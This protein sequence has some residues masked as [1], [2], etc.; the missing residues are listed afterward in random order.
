MIYGGPFKGS[1]LGG[2]LALGVT[3]TSLTEN[4]GSQAAEK[5]ALREAGRLALAGTFS[6]HSTCGGDR[7]AV[8]LL[9]EP[10]PSSLKG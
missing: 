8:V 2:V 10:R 9:R 7:W 4:P 5:V 6:V 1:A 3:D